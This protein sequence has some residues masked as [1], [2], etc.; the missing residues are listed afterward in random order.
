[1]GVLYVIGGLVL[2]GLASALIDALKQRRINFEEWRQFQ[3]DQ[4]D[5]K[6]RE[7]Q[8]TAA[9]ELFDRLKSQ[10]T[11]ALEVIA[12]EKSQGFPWLASAY[13]DYFK[14][15]DLEFAALLGV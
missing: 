5:L 9:Q 1:V 11:E 6:L 12:A 10:S 14:L 4:R 2:F 15:W 13:S 3:E 8:L 7:D